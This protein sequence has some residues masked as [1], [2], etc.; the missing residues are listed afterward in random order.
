MVPLLKAA[1]LYRP[2]TIHLTSRLLEHLLPTAFMCRVQVQ[3]FC[4]HTSI[5]TVFVIIVTQVPP[6]MASYWLNAL[7]WCHKPPMIIT[8][9]CALEL[10]A[11][12]ESCRNWGSAK[13]WFGLPETH[14]AMVYSD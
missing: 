14:M 4:E 3:C 11:I 2:Y 10:T 6:S 1:A 5:S 8:A 12:H 7:A 9:R 13:V